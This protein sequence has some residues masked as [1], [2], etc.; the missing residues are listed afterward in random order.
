MGLTRQSVRSGIS[1]VSVLS[2]FRPT[3]LAFIAF[4][5][6]YALQVVTGSE[7]VGLLPYVLLVP[8]LTLYVLKTMLLRRN[9]AR[10][11]GVGS[12]D[13]LV[14]AFMGFATAHIIA[15]ALFGGYRLTDVVRLFL[16]FVMSGWVYLYVSR[17]ATANG[18][19]LIMAAIALATVVMSVQWVYETYTKM[20]KKENTQFQ[21]LSYEYKKKRNNVTD[22]GMNPSTLG[23][24]YRAHGLADSHPTTG[25][26]V[27]IGSFAFVALSSRQSRRWRVLVLGL[28]LAVLLVGFATTAVVSYVILFPVIL[29]LSSKNRR[30]FVVLGRVGLYSAGAALVLSV[31]ALSTRWGR[32]LL[33][34][35]L[36]LLGLQIDYVLGNPGVTSFYVVYRNMIAQYLEFLGQKP[37]AILFGEGPVGY[38][39]VTFPRGGDIG[40]LDLAA[41]FGVPFTIYFFT[42]CVVAFRSGAR[43]IKDGRLEHSQAMNVIF[44]CATVAL[45]LISFVH[46]GVFFNKAVV[47][48]F[49][50]ALGL[51]RRYSFRGLAVP[52]VGPREVPMHPAY[53]AA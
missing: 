16:I 42:V 10:I 51:L 30:I 32:D 33:A 52:F 45:L 17:L 47:A 31:V 41:G 5:F 13:L 23:T 9:G 50:L 19:R 1:F 22:E 24:Q 3:P 27:A 25:T 36:L 2:I 34:N 20:V 28:F 21:Q 7:L 39:A 46:Y 49:Y 15:G 18:I 40:L 44:G 29:W 8:S 12:L 37:V 53:A 14:S 43:A 38:G 4:F 48:L 26:L 35:T 11:L 6:S